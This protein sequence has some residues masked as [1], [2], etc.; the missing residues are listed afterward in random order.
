MTDRTCYHYKYYE[1]DDDYRTFGPR[2]LRSV[3]PED[4]AWLIAEEAAKD[5]YEDGGY[6]SWHND[7][8]NFTILLPDGTLLGKFEVFLEYEPTF[9]ATEIK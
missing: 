8:R 5:Y 6:E 4:S 2:S 7:S 3:W 1:D 9:F